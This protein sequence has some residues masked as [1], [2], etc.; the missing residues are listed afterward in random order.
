MKS[1]AIALVLWVEIVSDGIRYVCA[2]IPPAGV[3]LMP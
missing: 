3:D 1:A 2:E